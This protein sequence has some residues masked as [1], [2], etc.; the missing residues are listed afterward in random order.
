MD[1]RLVRKGISNVRSPLK[2]SNCFKH[3][4]SLPPLLSYENDIS[5]CTIELQKG[6]L[7]LYP[8]DTI[9]GIGCD[10]TND[11]AVEKIYKIKKRSDKKA[12]IILLADEKDILKYATQPN[13]EIFDYIKDI[14]KPTTFIYEGGTG[15]SEKLITEDGTIAI[16]LTNE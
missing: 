15:I 10:A 9:W 2:R 4:Q 16:R 7:I 6:G 3:Y 14:K 1:T 12:M 11:A 5:Q 8:T 13:L